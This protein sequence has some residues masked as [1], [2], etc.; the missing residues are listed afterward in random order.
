MHNTWDIV[1][2]KGT[3]SSRPE[4]ELASDAPARGRVVLIAGLARALALPRAVGRTRTV[5]HA[6][7]P[8]ALRPGF[9]LLKLGCEHP[10]HLRGRQRQLGRD[11]RVRQRR[12]VLVLE[13]LR[14]G[15][16]QRSSASERSACLQ[17]RR[18]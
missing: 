3:N 9:L 6:L 15:R 14:T 1:V 11:R 17:E 7:S 4:V 18:R 5:R 16:M 13:C 8:L 12:E 2:D 10:R